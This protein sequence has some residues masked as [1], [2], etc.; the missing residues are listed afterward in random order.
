ME[1]ERRVDRVAEEAIGT[2]LPEAENLQEA[3]EEA[4]EAQKRCTV[5]DSKTVMAKMLR[6]N[7]E[8]LW[9]IIRLTKDEDQVRYIAGRITQ[10]WENAERFLA[11][12]P[13]KKIQEAMAEAEKLITMA[14]EAQRVAEECATVVNT[15]AEHRHKAEQVAQEMSVAV[16][17][18]N[19]I[20][21]QIEDLMADVQSGQQAYS[22]AVVQTTSEAKK[23]AQAAR[24]SEAHSESCSAA[25]S[26][27]QD[28]VKISSQLLNDLRKTEADSKRVLNISE[29]AGIA[30]AF[31]RK[32]QELEN[33][34]MGKWGWNAVSAMSAAIAV[35]VTLH[36]AYQL[37]AAL[38]ASDTALTLTQVGIL[39]IAK[40]GTV[41]ILLLTAG[42][43]GK[44]QEKWRKTRECYAHKSAIA[45]S[46]KA[47]VE[48][49]DKYEDEE[50]KRAYLTDALAGITE[51][52]E[53]LHALP[54][55][56]KRKL[57]VTTPVGTIKHQ[58]GRST[59]E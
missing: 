9:E 19:G 20:K 29:A 16:E 56:T 32:E 2:W 43:A 11:E 25:E 40:A 36:G 4:L 27:C 50:S 7:I 17:Q 45:A 59:E 52:P 1:N 26:T 41:A 47:F 21:G 53:A 22:E 8:G 49:L 35:A 24:Q 28:I 38:Q 48:E 23:A 5:K 18:M 30:K 3:L 58:D 46:I 42:Y 12:N 15:F 31:R 55:R 39:A 54:S 6:E 34:K 14:P 57:S 33:E 37:T 51:H 13:M 10:T 44:Q